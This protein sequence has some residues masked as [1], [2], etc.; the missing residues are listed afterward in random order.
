VRRVAGH[1]A[2]SHHRPY[3]INVA[4]AGVAGESNTIR[5][6]NV[7]P[8]TDL[9]GFVHPVHTATFIAGISGQTAPSGVAVYINT[10]GQLG[11]LTSSL[12]RNP[13]AQKN[14][15]RRWAAH[16]IISALVI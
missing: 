8:F 11:T 9:Y 15:A 14:S 4:T 10:D 6:G 12:G 5:I 13:T 2:H 1:G 3:N 7:P 16:I